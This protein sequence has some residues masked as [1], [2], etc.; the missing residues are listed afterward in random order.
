[1][2]V[3]GRGPASFM[4]LSFP[5][6]VAD[7]CC[8]LRFQEGADWG[9]GRWMKGRGEDRGHPGPTVLLHSCLYTQPGNLKFLCRGGWW[10]QAVTRCLVELV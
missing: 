10:L 7:S 5:S 6:C 4:N 2:W 9:E 8:D 3:G 1:M